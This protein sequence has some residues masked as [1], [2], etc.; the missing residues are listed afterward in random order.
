MGREIKS[1]QG[2]CPHRCTP[3]MRADVMT[4]RMPATAQ[5]TA[6]CAGSAVLGSHTATELFLP[7]D[8]HIKKSNFQRFPLL[9]LRVRATTRDGEDHVGSG[10][11]DAALP[12]GLRAQTTRGVC[13]SPSLNLRLF[14]LCIDIA[15]SMPCA[16]D[17]WGLLLRAAARWLMR[18]YYT[19]CRYA[20][21]YRRA[22]C[23]RTAHWQRC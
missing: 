14:A 1:V 2:P 10:P 11:H 8:V 6:C 18:H 21:R 20:A 23:L 9:C 12:N 17:P 22:A 19:D 3:S 13:P 7:P 16:F 15:Y 5:D 4:R